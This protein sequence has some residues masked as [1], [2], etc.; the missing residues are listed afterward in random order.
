MWEKLWAA[1]EQLIGTGA[2]VKE[3]K[4]YTYGHSKFEAGELAVLRRAFVT[5]ARE[6]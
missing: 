1:A 2:A 6:V 5:H 4:L 3:N